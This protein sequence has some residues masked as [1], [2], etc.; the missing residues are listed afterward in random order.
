MIIDIHTHIFPPEIRHHRQNFLKNEAAFT[1]LYKSETAKIV[2]ADKIVAAMD[3][4]GV[5][6]SVVFGFP[7][8]SPQTT[9]Q[10]NDYIIEAV[11]R[12]PKRLIGFACVDPFD[13]TAPEEVERC[14]SAGLTGVGELAFYESG[15]D[16]AAQDRLE[17]IMASAR[18][19]SVP[20]LIHT[21]EPVGHLYPGKTENTLS[22]IYSLVKRYCDNTIILAHFGG[23]LFFYNL[24]KK[25]VR[26][27]F[28]N[29][30]FDTAAAPYLYQPEVYRVAID[31]IGP[32]KILF[33]S[34]YPLIPPKRYF[35]EMKQGGLS[36][37]EFT[38]ICGKNARRL[39]LPK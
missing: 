7:W 2:G 17:P 26:K 37:D 34:D 21:N 18:A 12:Y 5:D 1:L 32:E 25:E 22:Q 33:G 4:Q 23:G 19:R 38:T 39:L 6:K 3:E 8:R 15:I 14:L 11:N 29:I 36:Q 20:V 31:I 16:E 24:L 30:Y 13:N 9:R 10:H 27:T 35:E 28:Q